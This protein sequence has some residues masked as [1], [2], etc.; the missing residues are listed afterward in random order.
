MQHF[1]LK[2]DE[3]VLWSKEYEQYLDT[4]KGK[5]QILPSMFHKEM[6]CCRHLAFS[7][8]KHMPNFWF[9]EM[10]HKIFVLFQATK[11]VLFCYMSHR[12]PMSMGCKIFWLG[13][14]LPLCLP[15]KPWKIIL[16]GESKTNGIFSL[17]MGKIYIGLL[18]GIFS[19][20]RQSNYCVNG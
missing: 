4:G 18:T 6:Q 17:S 2:V 13:S 11:F 7:P 8:V 16:N 1:G 10:Q 14:C 15:S 3:L 5:E 20:E 9:K 12:I 19:R